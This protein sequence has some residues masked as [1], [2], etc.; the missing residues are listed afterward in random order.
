M[1]AGTHA[2]TDP[3]WLGS[4]LASAG[5]TPP[6]A[7]LIEVTATE[8][9]FGRLAETSRLLLHWDPDLSPGPDSVVR[10]A[11]ST[12]S[13]SRA[14]GLD[15][16]AYLGE[17]RFYQELAEFVPITVP[18]CVH[19]DHDAHTGEFILILA[20]HASGRG[21]DQ[22]TGATVDEVALCLEEIARMHARY[23]G[24]RR[25][26]GLGWLPRW[27]DPVGTRR[28]GALYRHALREYSARFTDR[29]TD[30]EWQCVD[31]LSRDLRAWLGR[32]PG[33]YTLVH[34]DLRIDN[35]LFGLHGGPALT[36]LDWQTVNR[37][38][39]AGEAAYLIGGSL[40]TA[41][42]RRHEDELVQ[43]YRQAL[44][45]AGVPARDLGSEFAR[46]YRRHALA[47]VH[48]AV[49]SAAVLTSEP[50]D[51]F[52]TML[53]RHVAHVADVAAFDAL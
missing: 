18:S 7:R 25:L 31:R 44:A 1:I 13:R 19:A 12:R 22:R 29:A 27:C 14:F 21:V 26:D 30:D 28:L 36:V 49:T 48:R 11:P 46:T 40:P 9:G 53:G 42:R 32:D 47:G 39:A 23:W 20:D 17:V 2:C 50:D 5:L 34:G 10:K 3:A 33:P 41:L 4:V 24:G 38:P 43:H 52:T 45:A 37:G 8:I 16:N 6:R 35:T 51:L 15:S